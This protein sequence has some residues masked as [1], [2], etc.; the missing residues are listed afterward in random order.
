M[1]SL[2]V[3][4]RLPSSFIYVVVASGQD[5]G[6]AKKKMKYYRQRREIS[7]LKR[8]RPFIQSFFYCLIN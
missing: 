3:S 8:Q 1:I 4:P 2:F 6:R 5:P 7:F